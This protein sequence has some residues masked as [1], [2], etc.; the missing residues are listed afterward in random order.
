MPF[1]SLTVRRYVEPDYPRAAALRRLPGWV[2]VTFTVQVS[3]RTGDV[4]VAAADPPGL[5]EEAAVTAVRRWRF[6]PPAGTGAPG[7]LRSRIRVRFDPA[8]GPTQVAP[9]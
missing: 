8:S 9:P 6:A 3:G 1:S 2:D 4:A 7:P 5:F